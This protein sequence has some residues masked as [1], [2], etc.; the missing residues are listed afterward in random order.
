MKFQEIKQSVGE[1]QSKMCVIKKKLHGNF[2]GVF[3]HT[4]TSAVII[5]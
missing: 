3:R 5:W 1:I 2:N 4:L